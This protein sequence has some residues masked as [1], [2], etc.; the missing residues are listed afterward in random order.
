[1]YAVISLLSPYAS[2]SFVVQVKAE[3]GEE[4][5]HDGTSSFH[6]L[7]TQ[8][9]SDRRCL[10]SSPPAVFLL[11]KAYFL[12]LNLLHLFDCSYLPQL[13]QANWGISLNILEGPF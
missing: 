5:T 10:I 13:H 9:S 1:M 4:E 7:T 12:P 6:Y 3:Q 8:L 2:V 11:V